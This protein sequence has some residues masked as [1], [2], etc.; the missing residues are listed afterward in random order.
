MATTRRSFFAAAAGGGFWWQARG[1]NGPPGAAKRDMIVRSVRPQDLE[2][3]ISGFSAYIT[4]A[5]DFFVRTH[6]YV[7]TVNPGEWRLRVEGE[8]LSPLTLT[9]DDLRALP[10]VE[11]V[12]VLE[13]AGNGRSFYDPPVAGV[14]WANGAAGNGRWRGAR[15]ADVLK[16]AG[17]KSAAAQVLFDGADVPLGAM[18]DFQRTIPIKKALDPNTLLAYELNGEALP[19]QHGFPLRAVVPGWAGDS[20]M[21][22][23]SAVRVLDKESDGWWMKNAYRHP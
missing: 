3:P 11:V 13:C 9:M 17:V 16:K 18:A 12:S 7:P 22:W 10:A 23:V 19:V 20:W 4:P 8:V 14:Q 15:L 5:Q 1:Q 6:V 21:K 2:M